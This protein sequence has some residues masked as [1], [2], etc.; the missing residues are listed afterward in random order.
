MIFVELF[1]MHVV[2]LNINSILNFRHYFFFFNFGWN[3]E[4]NR[5]RVKVSAKIGSK[6]P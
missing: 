1:I 2:L 5:K 6:I 4:R 3:K